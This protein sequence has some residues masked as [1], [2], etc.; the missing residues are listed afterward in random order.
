[1]HKTLKLMAIGLLVTGCIPT[2]QTQWDVQPVVGTVVDGDT[3]EPV[4]DAVIANPARTSLSTIS[5]SQGRFA[6]EEQTHT[7]FHMAMP[8]SAMATETWRITHPDYA[9]AVAQTRT[10]IPPL[11]R[12]LSTLTIPLFRDLPDSPQTCPDFGYLL[13]LGQ[14]QAGHKMDL[15]YFQPQNCRDEASLNALEAVW[16]PQ[17]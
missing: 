15:R 10:L 16:F 13:K 9:D 17:S 8:A 14:W 12:Q 5:D 1:M 11:S 7:G 2:I 3:G 6:V 4:S